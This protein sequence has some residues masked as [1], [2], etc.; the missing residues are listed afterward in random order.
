MAAAVRTDG[1]L[2]VIPLFIRLGHCTEGFESNALGHSSFG[3]GAGR[4]SGAMNLG[5][6]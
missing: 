5:L 2:K 1:R 6:A 3:L 4:A